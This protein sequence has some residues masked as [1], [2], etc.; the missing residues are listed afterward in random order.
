MTGHQATHYP[1]G[2]TKINWTLH[3]HTQ[4][5][6]L[7]E[8]VKSETETFQRIGDYLYVLGIE[9]SSSMKC[10]SVT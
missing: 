6:V 9:R 3:H 10:K 8:N 2:K 4:K 1:H 7:G 5:S